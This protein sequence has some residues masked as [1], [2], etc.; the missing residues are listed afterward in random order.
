MKLE[1]CEQCGELRS[2][3]HRVTS[4]IIDA[5]VCSECAQQAAEIDAKPHLVG[6]LTVETLPRDRHCITREL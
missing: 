5:R 4:E 2:L 3:T 6:A 1:H